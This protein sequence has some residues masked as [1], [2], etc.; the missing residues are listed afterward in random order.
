MLLGPQMLARPGGLRSLEAEAL[1]RAADGSRVPLVDSTFPLSDAA[2]AHRALEGRKTYGK[3][4][5]IPEAVR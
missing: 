5:L 1:A 4:V 2:E 3:V